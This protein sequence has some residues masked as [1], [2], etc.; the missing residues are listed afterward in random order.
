MCRFI[1]ILVVAVLIGLVG[2]NSLVFAGQD[3]GTTRVGRYSTVNNQATIAQINPLLAIAQFKFQP[4]VQTIGDAIK[5]VLQNTSYALVPDKQ[6][7]QI[8][9]ET[10]KKQLPITVRTLG[11]LSIKEAVLVLMGKEV[12]DL[13]VDPAHRL[14]NFK[15]K[16]SILHTLGETN[17]HR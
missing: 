17:E 6:L 9:Q 5:Q 8:A 10:L 1:K 16:P 11:P 15:I 14:I 3:D 2:M 12:F 7:P 4:P 13:V